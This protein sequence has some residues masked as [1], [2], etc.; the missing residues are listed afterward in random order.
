MET[1][2]RSAV[3]AS[4]A[5]AV[6]AEAA[7]RR[8]VPHC[9]QNLTPGAFVAPH[10]GQG[11]DRA[12]PHSPQNFLSGSFAVPHAGQ[13]KVLSLH[14]AVPSIRGSGTRVN[15]HGRAQGAGVDVVMRRR[16][17]RVPAGGLLPPAGRPRPAG[18]RTFCGNNQR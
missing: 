18:P 5:S 15:V 8:S 4:R 13:S 16:T 12:A 14:S 7:A 17:G 2:R 11:L 1:R 10:V 3:G 6:V 9:P